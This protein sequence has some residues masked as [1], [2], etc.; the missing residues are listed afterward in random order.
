MAAPLAATAPPLARHRR[1][2]AVVRGLGRGGP[3]S[4]LARLR[5]EL[6]RGA[7]ARHAGLCP[8]ARAKRPA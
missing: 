7:L 8:L 1:A 6:A 2:S 3:S 4:P 5:V